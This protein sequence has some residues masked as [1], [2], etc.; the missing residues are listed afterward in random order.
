MLQYLRNGGPVPTAQRRE[1]W[2]KCAL[3]FDRK[4]GGS[5]SVEGRGVFYFSVPL[6]LMAPLA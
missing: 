3:R 2:R 4:V 6:V 5:K 1:K